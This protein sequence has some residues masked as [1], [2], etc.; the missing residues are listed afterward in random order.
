VSGE[1]SSG[2]D[3]NSRVEVIRALVPPDL[4][5]VHELL[6]DRVKASRLAEFHPVRGPEG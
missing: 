5:H 2:L 6:G 4:I 1:E 3:A